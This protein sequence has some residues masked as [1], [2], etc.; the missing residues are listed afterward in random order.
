MAIIQ[1]LTT[2]F[3]TELMDALHNFGTTVTRANTLPD[4]FKI[5]LYTINA[6]LGADTTVYTPVNEASGGSYVA[7][8][9]VLVSSQAP[10]ATGTV[11]WTNFA[12]IS[13][14]GSITA[15]GAL[16][17]NATQSNRA[18][19]VLSFG[20]TKTS[21]NTFTVKFPASTSTSAIVRIS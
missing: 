9:R 2:S 13:W 17:Y 6:S 7:G 16:I 11:A 19:A 20:G 1:T 18:V 15:A 21:K 5:A 4:T 12:D 10:T 8:G 3:K 14:T